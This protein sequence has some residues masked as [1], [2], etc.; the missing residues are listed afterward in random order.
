MARNET[1]IQYI[2]MDAPAPPAAGAHPGTRCE[3]VVPATLDLSDS[4]HF[5]YYIIP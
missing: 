3:E 5:L 1:D 4:L 2:R